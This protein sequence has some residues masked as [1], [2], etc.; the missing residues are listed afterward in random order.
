MMFTNYNQIED[1]FAKLNTDTSHYT[2]S[3]DI[4]T[5][6]GCVKE[7]VDAIPEE[8]WKRENIKILD[9]CAGNGNFPA[10]LALKTDISHIVCNEINPVRVNNLSNY[11]DGKIKITQVDFLEYPEE[12]KY[13]LIVANPPYAKLMTDGKRTA[14]NHTLSREF[15]K[16]S[17]N[18]LNDGGYLVFI[19][20]DNW[21]SFSDN[22]DLPRILSQY[23]I[24]TLNIGEAKKWFPSVGSSFTYFVVQKTANAGMPTKIITKDGITEA[25][26]DKGVPCIPL[27]YNEIIRSLFA[28]VVF[29]DLPKYEVK[30]NCSLH[31]Y[32]QAKLLSS[33][34]DAEHPYRV[35]HTP[36]QTIWSSKEHIYY[37]DWKVFLPTTT[38]YKPFVD[39]ECGMT[40]SINFVLCA[41]EPEAR[42]ICGELNEKV[43]KVIVDLTRYGNFNNQRILQN[44][45]RREYF[46]LTEKEQRFV[47]NYKCAGRGLTAE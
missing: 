21:M 41:D 43:Y 13:D 19:L 40:Q 47:D 46:E 12:E 42:K 14:K 9:P 7:M 23:N 29:T 38:Y 31:K 25:V 37:H 28:K 1:Y 35:I 15:V 30:V 26:I 8:L 27:R 32:T 18:L 6:I 11:F 24:L 44:L 22:N 39:N 2:S 34:E 36:N 10:Y 16:K 45:T 3:N 33:V 5:S 4:S 17:L 20:P